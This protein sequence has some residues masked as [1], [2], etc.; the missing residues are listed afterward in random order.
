M[1]G[2][3]KVLILQLI[4]K[5]IYDKWGDN[6]KLTPTVLKLQWSGLHENPNKY[7]GGVQ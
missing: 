1:K 3:I 6:I 4:Y 5:K 7:G 2:I